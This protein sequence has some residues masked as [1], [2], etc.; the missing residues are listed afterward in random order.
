PT[1]NSFGQIWQGIKTT[2]Q[3]AA[4]SLSDIFTEVNAGHKTPEK[5]KGESDQI[6]AETKQEITETVKKVEIAAAFTPEEITR[7][8][9]EAKRIDDFQK[10]T[11][12]WHEAIR[13]AD[14]TRAAPY[15]KDSFAQARDALEAAAGQINEIVNAPAEADPSGTEAKYADDDH[16]RTTANVLT[17]GLHK[18]RQ[19]L[20]D[21][22]NQQTKQEEEQRA[23]EARRAAANEAEKIAAQKYQTLLAAFNGRLLGDSYGFRLRNYES[24]GQEGSRY[25]PQ[26]YLAIIKDLE[27][28]Y[29]KIGL[30][31]SEQKIAELISIEDDIR[32]FCEL[33]K[34]TDEA[35]YTR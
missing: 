14:K 28:H 22:I 15:S 3:Q 30:R 4:K 20:Q 21:E 13:Q 7:L 26:E 10:I 8:Q 18:H 29:R 9:A 5:A 33:A 2:V 35:R 6:I 31:T 24:Y 11:D 32:I 25:S 34:L 16:I 12:I 17:D 19:E 27:A 23:E 1:E